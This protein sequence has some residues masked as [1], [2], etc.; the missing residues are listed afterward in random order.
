ML[1]THSWHSRYSIAAKRISF[2]ARSSF[3]CG[4]VARGSCLSTQSPTRLER[5]VDDTEPVG[6]PED[7]VKS[8]LGFCFGIWSARARRPRFQRVLTQTD[9]LE[10]PGR[11]CGC[12][13]TSAFLFGGI[14]VRRF[15]ATMEV[16]R[17]GRS[18][19]SAGAGASYGVIDNRSENLQHRQWTPCSLS[20]EFRLP[21]S[22]TLS[23]QR[24]SLSVDSARLRAAPTSICTRGLRRLLFRAMG[25][26]RTRRRMEL[27]RMART[28]VAAS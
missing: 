21:R 3:I 16:G 24:C 17:S 4:S 8:K 20:P 10:P 28:A 7:R 9:L 1:F 5:I 12:W 2:F 22:W 11:R 14:V 23:L 15:G 13:A 25:W 27:G 19:M 6:M 18:M 26:R